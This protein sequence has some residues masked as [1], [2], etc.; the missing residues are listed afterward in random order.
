MSKTNGWATES[1]DNPA[2]GRS[3]APV[4]RFLFARPR[5]SLGLTVV[6]ES[7]QGYSIR[8]RLGLS[9]MLIAV[10]AGASPAQAF[11]RHRY[12]CPPVVHRHHVHRAPVYRSFNYCPPIHHHYRPHTYHHHWPSYCPPVIRY[13]YSVPYCYPGYGYS[14]SYSYGYGYGYPI[15]W[16]AA[17]PIGGGVWPIGGFGGASIPNDGS[18]ALF[19]RGAD[20]G[21]NPHSANFESSTASGLASA[22]TYDYRRDAYDARDLRADGGSP[23]V[24][25]AVQGIFGPNE[26]Q[27]VVDLVARVADSVREAREARE[28]RQASANAASNPAEPERSAAP[29]PSTAPRRPLL[30]AAARAL[31]GAAQ[32]GQVAQELPVAPRIASPN[33]SGTV[34]R[35]ISPLS[36]RPFARPSSDPAPQE[37]E[38]P[39]DNS[40]PETAPAPTQPELP[41]PSVDRAPFEAQ[42]AVPQASSEAA[43]RRAAKYVQQGDQLFAR[44]RYLEAMS[45]YQRAA[46]STPDSAQPLIRQG[47]AYLAANRYERAAETIRRGLRL[48]PDYATSGFRL[49]HLYAGDLGAK[50]KHLEALAEAA[51]ADPGNADLPLLAAI[52]LHYDG[53]T[54]RAASFFAASQKSDRETAE[55]VSLFR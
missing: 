26:T 40:P 13:R 44:G 38:Q 29:Q 2:R 55:F 48:E 17:L 51:K 20:L 9:A 24:P 5:S 22:R 37:A 32:G 52:F 14:Y 54:D 23:A 11:H 30:A 50:N 28:A 3:G 1:S 34:D 42:Q 35:R 10:C 33:R 7:G 4:R 46:S 18:I 21:G 6:G 15:N 16:T 39:L 41:E 27:T 25:G 36:E 43:R 49:N 45:V 31:A 47:L 53:Q 8:F 12:V 19:G